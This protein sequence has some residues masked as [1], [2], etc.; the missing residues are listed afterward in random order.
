ML[1]EATTNIDVLSDNVTSLETT[2][3]AINDNLKTCKTDLTACTDDK[4]KAIDATTFDPA[5]NPDDVSFQP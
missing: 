4:C 5:F 3:K 2:M 1:G